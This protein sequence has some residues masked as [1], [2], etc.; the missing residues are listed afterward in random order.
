M[1]SLVRLEA[2]MPVF[3]NELDAELAQYVSIMHAWIRGNLDWYSYTDR[4]QSIEMLEL[5]QY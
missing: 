2:S 1:E 4:Y 3:G 5:V